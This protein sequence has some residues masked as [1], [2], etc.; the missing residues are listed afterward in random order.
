MVLPKEALTGVD[1]IDDYVGHYME[2]LDTPPIFNMTGILVAMSAVLS[3]RVYVNRLEGR[4]MPN[5][6]AIL[7]GYS[8]YSRKTTAQRLTLN[9]VPENAIYRCPEDTTPEKLIE[10]M[11]E[12]DRILLIKDEI[13]GMFDRS[14]REY[15]KGFKDLLLEAYEGFPHG[16]TRKL[17]KESFEIKDIYFVLYGGTT[18]SR[19]MKTMSVEDVEIGLIPRMLMPFGEIK[20]YKR[21]PM[22][23]SDEIQFREIMKTRLRNLSRF[24]MRRPVMEISDSMWDMYQDLCEELFERSK[25]DRKVMLPFYS[26]GEVYVMKLAMIIAASEFSNQIR[27]TDLMRAY[28][29]YNMYIPHYHRVCDILERS[30]MTSKDYI[31]TEAVLDTIRSA[32]DNGITKSEILRKNRTIHGV[33]LDTILHTLILRGE[34]DTDKVGKKGVRYIYVGQ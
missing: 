14:S 22:L 24:M 10:I 28:N 33:R 27:E 20:E 15:M 16:Y 19:I 6:W 30:N 17:R 2:Y 1:I 4:V 9:V 3:Q 11:S 21:P 34:I 5:L 13:G 25:K 8:S 26:R 7:I 23:T 31:E 29:L 32:G 12:E 18:I